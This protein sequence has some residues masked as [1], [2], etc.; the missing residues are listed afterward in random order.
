MIDKLL[1]QRIAEKAYSIYEYRIANNLPGSAEQDWDEATSEII[2][3]RRIN[4]CCPVC[5]F[6]LLARNDGEIFCLSIT[7]DWK[8]KHRRNIDKDIPDFNTIKKDWQ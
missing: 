3:D 6:P 5:N 2:P 4:N 7:C 1:N 8:I